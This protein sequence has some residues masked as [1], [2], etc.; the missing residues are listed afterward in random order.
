[1]NKIL[2][3]LVG[4]TT[5]V[6]GLSAMAP[7]KKVAPAAHRTI[8]K[9]QDGRPDVSL[10]AYKLLTGKE[11]Y[12]S[13]SA[14]LNLPKTY[15]RSQLNSLYQERLKQFNQ[16]K[17]WQQGGTDAVRLIEWAHAELNKK[18]NN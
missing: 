7:A 18:Y 4:L 8:A 11:E 14:I 5:F 12:A 2:L 9:P 1:M 15:T 10:A 17:D 13:P 6:N 16:R 3:T